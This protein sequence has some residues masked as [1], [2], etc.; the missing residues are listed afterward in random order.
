ML[1]RKNEMKQME[2]MMEKLM[3]QIEELRAEVNNIKNAPKD[4]EDPVVALEE[5]VDKIINGNVTKNEEEVPVFKFNKRHE[6]MIEK[7]MNGGICTTKDDA[8]AEYL[9]KNVHLYSIFVDDLGD[10]RYELSLDP[11]EVARKNAPKPEPKK[12]EL[13]IWE[14]KGAV[15]FKKTTL[16]T[17]LPYFEPKKYDGNYRWGCKTDGYNQ[18]SYMGRR[19]AFCVFM[20]T[21]G[22][23]W[24]SNKAY[25][26]GCKIDYAPNGSY[27][28]AKALFEETFKYIKKSDR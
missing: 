4:V 7:V 15:D 12:D 3:A 6:N 16:K 25:K 2:Q 27:Y 8:F 5:Y 20:A 28:K 19:K 24:D 26:D 13:R 23:Y 1:G 11:T 10:G 9:D 21:D 17:L 14:Y 18:K 22:R